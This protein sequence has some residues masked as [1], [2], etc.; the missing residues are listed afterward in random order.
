VS[1]EE[2][3]TRY[4]DEI[5]QFKAVHK[6][7]LEAITWGK[8]NGKMNYRIADFFRYYD[9]L[10]QLHWEAMNSELLAGQEEIQ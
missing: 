5:G 1:E 6:K 3:K 4:A 7:V 9:D 10:L 8:N 2:W